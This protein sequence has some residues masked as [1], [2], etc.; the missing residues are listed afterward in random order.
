MLQTREKIPY[1]TSDT[2]IVGAFLSLSGCNCTCVSC[3]GCVDCVY[4]VN[5]A[6]DDIVMNVYR[7]GLTPDKQYFVQYPAYSIQGIDVQFFIDDILKNATSGYYIG[8][9]VVRGNACGSIEMLVGDNNT[10]FS[11]YTQ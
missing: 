7:K 3:Q 10:V 4:C 2:D 11:P 1:V 6:V 9:V 5:L 8:D